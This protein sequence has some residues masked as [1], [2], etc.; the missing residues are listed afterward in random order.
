MGLNNFFDSQNYKKM[1]LLGQT[2]LQAHFE[3]PFCKIGFKVLRHNNLFVLRNKN[4][5]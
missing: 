5:N 4:I 2:F 3:M 1:G